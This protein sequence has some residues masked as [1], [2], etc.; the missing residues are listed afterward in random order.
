MPSSL[1]R[2]TLVGYSKGSDRKSKGGP[3]WDI[4]NWN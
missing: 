3:T 1:T 4:W 2:S